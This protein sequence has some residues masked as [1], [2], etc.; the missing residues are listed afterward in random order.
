MGREG[1]RK[2][3][4][5]GYGSRSVISWQTRVDSTTLCTVHGARAFL[6]IHE[7]EPP[8]RAVFKLAR[9][10]NAFLGSDGGARRLDIDGYTYIRLELRG[11]LHVLPAIGRS[12]R[13][14]FRFLRSLSE[15]FFELQRKIYRYFWNSGI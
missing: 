9:R 1:G 12:R 3:F 6:L 8:W 11:V 15:R 10:R 4:A 2:R 7:T 14:S 13:T 5:H